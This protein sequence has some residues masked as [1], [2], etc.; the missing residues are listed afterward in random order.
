MYNKLAI[1]FLK[2]ID[3]TYRTEEEEIMDDFSLEGE[4]LRD[5]LDKIAII[6]QYNKFLLL[7]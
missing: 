3:T 1:K 4:E 2:H 5:A 7:Y 6:N